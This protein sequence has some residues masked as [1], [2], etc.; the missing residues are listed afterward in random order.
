M[1][2]IVKS[3]FNKEVSFGYF[4]CQDVVLITV[5]VF[6]RVL[7]MIRQTTT[8]MRGIPFQRLEIKTLDRTVSKILGLGLFMDSV[9]MHLPI[10]NYIPVRHD[11][12]PG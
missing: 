1:I 9:N 6:H 2:T 12:K 8:F 11:Y 5:D 10:N 7:D 3:G 4:S